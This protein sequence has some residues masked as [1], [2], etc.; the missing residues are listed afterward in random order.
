MAEIVAFQ[1]RAQRAHN[2]VA[3]PIPAAGPVVAPSPV[4]ALQYQR[5]QVIE[6]CRAL[7]DTFKQTGRWDAMCEEDMI[8]VVKL[9]HEIAGRVTAPNTGDDHG[10]TIPR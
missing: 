2:M 4:D 9:L 6:H 1:T 10:Q 7:V 3:A 5:K 8:Q